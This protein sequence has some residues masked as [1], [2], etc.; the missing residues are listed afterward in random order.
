[1]CTKINRVF[2]KKLDS[3]GMP[4]RDNMHKIKEIVSK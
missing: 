3:G 4:P 2:P 1:M